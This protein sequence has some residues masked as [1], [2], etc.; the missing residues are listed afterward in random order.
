MTTGTDYKYKDHFLSR[1][2]FQ[3]RWAQERSSQKKQGDVFSTFRA[4]IM[5]ALM[6]FNGTMA[7]LDKQVRPMASG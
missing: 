7:P 1:T 4:A 2:H 3:R 5:T 6:D